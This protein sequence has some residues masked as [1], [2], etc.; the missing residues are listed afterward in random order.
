MDNTFSRFDAFGEILYDES[1]Y[2][3]FRNAGIDCL[4]DLASDNIV[5]L[6]QKTI[7]LYSGARST[8]AKRRYFPF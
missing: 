7:W 2:I 8:D 6:C 3:E 1:F 4:W 5:V